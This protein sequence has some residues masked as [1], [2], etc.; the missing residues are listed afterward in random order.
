MFL[1]IY[2]PV[3]LGQ[4]ENGFSFSVFES[5]QKYFVNIKIHVRVLQETKLQVD[6]STKYLVELT[7]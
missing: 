3:F 1:K 6:E 2:H 7:Q 5:S 4:V